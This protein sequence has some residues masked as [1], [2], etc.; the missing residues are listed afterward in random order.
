MHHIA[1][2]AIDKTVHGNFGNPKGPKVNFPYQ[3]GGYSNTGYIDGTDLMIKQH[4]N[5]TEQEVYMV[6]SQVGEWL[7]DPQGGP[8]NAPE[9]LSGLIYLQLS[10]IH[11][12]RDRLLR[13]LPIPVAMGGTSDN[14]VVVLL[15]QI[16]D[17]MDQVVL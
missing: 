10:I 4:L 1:R 7:K 3:V 14:S 5:P 15:I 13:S 9:V 17:L 8:E 12:H 2:Q 16:K 11:S 6:M